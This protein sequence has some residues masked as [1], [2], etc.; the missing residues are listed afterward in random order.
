MSSPLFRFLFNLSQ[1]CFA[2][3]TIKVLYIFWIIGLN[4]KANLEN[5]Y[6]KIFM[7]LGAANVF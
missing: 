1:Q 4:V 6:W 7:T 3:I 2:F 5:L